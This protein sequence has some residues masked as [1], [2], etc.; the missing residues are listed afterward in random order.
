MNYKILFLLTFT[1]ALL[2]GCGSKSGSSFELRPYAD[3]GVAVGGTVLVEAD[4]DKGFHWPYL[5]Y[6][7]EGLDKESRLLVLPNNTGSTS[8]D[9]EVHRRK[10]EKDLRFALFDFEK[11]GLKRAILVPIFSRPA[12]RIA[13]K[14]VYSHSLDRDTI[15]LKEEAV[16]G[17]KMAVKIRWE[18]EKMGEGS[19]MHYNLG[20]I[21]AIQDGLAYRCYLS[22]HNPKTAITGVSTFDLTFIIEPG[23]DY[24][25][26]FTLMEA[27]PA[28]YEGFLFKDLRLDNGR[29]VNGECLAGSGVSVEAIS[30]AGSMADETLYDPYGIAVE[31]YR[32]YRNDLQLIAMIEDAKKRITGETEFRV[33]QKFDMV[34][35]SAAATFSERFTALHPQLV[36]SIAAGGFNGILLLPEESYKGD[37]LAYP[38]GTADYKE[39]TGRDFDPVA[40]G[41]VKRFLFM[42]GSDTND[43]ATYRDSYSVESEEL[44]MKHFGRLPAARVPFLKERFAESAG[45]NSRFKVYEGVE[46]AFTPEMAAD[47]VEFFNNN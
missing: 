5:L 21:I 12:S 2:T 46:H 17:E 47:V 42:G 35:Y 34:G 29:V 45:E 23:I 18:G 8:D 4:S 3:G 32:Y 19:S 15:Y 1:I 7:P 30:P 33:K 31:I 11:L 27:I 40:F 41:E 36:N 38:L 22:D 6:L 16:L 14:V 28:E 10:A 37:R 39:I 43:A 25:R 20:D 26:G 24:S 13:G 9:F 44:V